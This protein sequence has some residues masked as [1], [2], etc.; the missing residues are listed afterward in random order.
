MASYFR[1]ASVSVGVD[2]VNRV[3]RMVIDTIIVN[4]RS[5]YT[6]LFVDERW[7]QVCQ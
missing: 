4:S 7:Q 3:L 2:E 1:R 5:N 6:T